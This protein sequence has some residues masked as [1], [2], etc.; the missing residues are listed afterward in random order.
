MARV[1]TPSFIVDLPLEVNTSAARHL[2][3]RFRCGTKLTN[4]MTQHARTLVEALRAD[5]RWAEARTLPKAK[6]PDAYKALRQAHGFSSMAFD[7]LV[8]QHARAAGFYGRLGSHEMQAIAKR[9]FNAADEWLC[10]KRGKLRFKGYR[11]PVHSLEGKN[12]TGMLQWKPDARALQ[13]EKGF[14][15]PASLPDLNKDEWLASALQA[16]P[17]YCRLL[18]RNVRGE[19]RWF[20]QLVQEGLTPLKAALLEK[21]AAEDRIGGIDLGP[22]TLAW[23]TP[24][25][26]GLVKLCAEI[27]RPERLIRRLQRKL[28]RQRRAANPNNFN[29]D[30]TVKRGCRNW[31]ASMRQRKVEP[32]LANLQRQ[33]AVIRRASHGRLVNMLLTQARHWKDDGVSPKALQR[34]YGKS[35]GKRAP[36]FLMSE[37]KRKAERAGGSRTLIDVRNLKTSQYCHAADDFVKK[38]LSQRWHVFRD[39]RGKVQRDVYSAFLAMQ[40]EGSTHNQARLETAWREMTSML[41]GA[42]LCE[43]R[44]EG[45]AC[46][47]TE[48]HSGFRQ[49]ASPASPGC[50]SRGTGDPGLNDAC[51]A[52][53]RR[54]PGYSG[55]LGL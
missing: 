34:R 39:G 15:L 42:G 28:D 10:G 14:T 18:W 43:V 45:L 46:K 4:V 5:P 16:K 7:A 37:L 26:A 54:A 24:T 44:C 11:R 1:S 48:I 33:E 20:V 41:S 36:G 29:A 55:T 9:V 3:D 6:R 32:Q 12:N 25:A 35:V 31:V 17:K 13:V 27:D 21:L 23:C 38:P 40:A 50:R 8:A 51:S 53:P 2:L 22:S 30:G 47:P 49:S 19:R 52:S